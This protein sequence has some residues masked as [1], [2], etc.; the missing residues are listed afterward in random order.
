VVRR[1]YRLCQKCVEREGGKASAFEAVPGRDCFVCAGIMDRTGRMAIMA[2]RRARQYQFT[3]FSVGVSV[4]EGVQEREDELR[5][6]MKLKGNETIK[7]QVAKLVAAAVSKELG[8]KVDR[9][10]PDVTLLVDFNAG[11]VSATSRPVY[12]YGRYTKPEGVSQRRSICDHCQGAGCKKCRDAGFDQRP[13]VEGML[14]RKLAKFSGGEKMIFTWLGSEDRE[15]RV[16]APGRPFVAEI[17]GPKKRAL[18]RKFGARLGGGLVSVSSGRV[19]PSKPVRLPSF[20]FLTRI[21]AVAKSKVDPEGLAELESRFH[22]AAVRFER[23]RNRPTVKMVYRVSA[24]TRGRTL[25]ISAELDGG[26]PVKR[27]VSGDL[28][29]PSVSEV[30]KTEVGCRSFDICGVKEIGE[31]GFGEITRTEEKN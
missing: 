1:V 11:N 18:P 21:R 5:S 19:L 22:R 28:V 4:P 23:P 12:F 14:L 10:R 25:F 13:S 24:K 2:T 30:L 7:T 31:F 8:K 17:K 9:V 15:S 16:S 27:F 20:R 26:L 6:E 29:S 3:T